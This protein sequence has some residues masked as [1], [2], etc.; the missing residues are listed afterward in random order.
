MVVIPGHARF[1]DHAHLEER[2]EHERVVVEQSLLHLHSQLRALGGVELNG[3]LLLQFFDHIGVVMSLV[4]GRAVQAEGREE[5]LRIPDARVD[6]RGGVDVPRAHIRDDT[7]V[8]RRAVDVDVDPDVPKRRLR[9]LCQKRELLTARIS[10][11]ADPER[12]SVLLTYPVAVRIGP[13]G[14]LEQRPGAVRIVSLCHQGRSAER[15][16]V[17]ESARGDLP[18]PIQERRDEPLFVDPHGN[19]FADHRVRGERALIIHPAEERAGS[20]DL[21]EPV[22]VIGEQRVSLVGHAVSGVDIAC[23]QRRRKRVAVRDRAD[24]QLVEVRG[25]APVILVFDQFQVVAAH[26]VHCDIRARARD[27]PA[28][29]PRVHVDDAAVRVTQI[30][31]KCRARLPGLQRQNIALRPDLL[32]H[33]VAGRP[34]VILYKVFQALLYRLGVHR[35]AG[36]KCHAVAQSDLPRVLIHV[37]PRSRQPRCKLHVVGE[38]EER[39]SDAIADRRPA[40]IIVVRVHIRLRV[41]R[42]ESRVADGHRLLS[43]CLRICTAFRLRACCAAFRLRACVGP[44]CGSRRLR[45]ITAP[46]LAAAAGQNTDQ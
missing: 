27:D 45:A 41:L 9:G 1:R 32:Q 44:F 29:E 25:T 28:V 8:I 12:L 39:L 30:I 19:G 38:L 3:H 31:E 10:E 36:R 40:G 35:P 26:A 34:V 17:R 4:L 24:R 6:V 16:A 5:V 2:A 13:P 33:Q 7:V 22:I 46:G 43:C 18:V 20:R 21:R 11:P 14:F 42:V 37:L 23:L 15:K